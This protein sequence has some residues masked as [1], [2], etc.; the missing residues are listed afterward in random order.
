MLAHQHRSFTLGSIIV[1][2][3]LGAVALSLLFLKTHPEHIVVKSSDGVVEVE[4]DV[5]SSVSISILRDDGASAKKWTAVD[6]GIYIVEPMTS[7]G[8]VVV[9]VK[10]ANARTT[11]IMPLDILM[12]N[13]AFGCRRKRPK[14]KRRDFLKRRRRIFRHGRF[15][16]FRKALKL[17]ITICLRCLTRRESVCRR[18]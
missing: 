12:L 5:P 16:A 13:E 17:P 4:G 3:C 11:M 1:V 8:A 2:L 10:S 18:I 14:T 9:R 15:F 7:S 6:G